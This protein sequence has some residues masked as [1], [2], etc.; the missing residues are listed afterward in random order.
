MIAQGMP[1]IE[2]NR[3]T[4]LE[5]FSCFVAILP[6]FN[7]DVLHKLYL[8]IFEKY[9]PQKENNRYKLRAITCADLLQSPE[10]ERIG[11]NSFII[12]PSL[13]DQLRHKLMEKDPG[14]DIL[15]D[16]GNFMLSYTWECKAHFPSL[17][18]LE[19][20]RIE[21]NIILNPI[22]EA[23]RVTQNIV[24]RFNRLKN[25][26]DR[27]N[28]VGYYLKVLNQNSL[29]AEQEKLVEFLNIYQSLDQNTEQVTEPQ[30]EILRNLLNQDPNSSESITIKLPNEIKKKIL[31][32]IKATTTTPS[33]LHALIIGVDKYQNNNSQ[34]PT[35]ATSEAQAVSDYL[36]Q[37]VAEGRSCNT[38]L[39][40]NQDANYHAIQDYVT[41]YLFK[42]IKPG[43]SFVLY[44]IGQGG[45]VNS[46]DLE[47]QVKNGNSSHFNLSPLIELA[48]MLQKK[49]IEC[50]ILNDESTLSLL[51]LLVYLDRL[52]RDCTFT[53]ILD[54]EFN[55]KV[56]PVQLSKSLGDG[57][58]KMTASDTISLNGVFIKNT[59]GRQ[60]AVTTTE[61]GYFTRSLLH[62]LQLTEKNITNQQLIN[63][64]NIFLNALKSG[65]K[66]KVKAFGN[67]SVTD[68][69]LN[70]FLATPFAECLKLIQTNKENKDPELKLNGM[71]LTFLPQALFDLEHLKV[72]DI[73][74]NAIRSFPEIMSNLINLEEINLNDNPIDPSKS[75]LENLK[76]L[77]ILKMHG[78][79]LNVFPRLI[80]GLHQLEELDLSNNTIRFLPN[81]LRN[82]PNLKNLHLTG[83]PLNFDIPG[84]G[85][86][87]MAYF[88]DLSGAENS[89]TNAPLMMVISLDYDNRLPNI[90]PE[91]EQ[92]SA[93]C[94]QSDLEIIQL[95]NP[96][97]A[98][99]NNS[100][101]MYQNRLAIIHFASFDMGVLADSD[102]KPQKMQPKDW[103][104]FFKCIKTE[105]F[106]TSLLFLNSCYGEDLIN[107]L[108]KDTFKLGLGLKD[109]I[110][111]WTAYNFATQFYR[112]LAS[113]GKTIEEAL[114]NAQ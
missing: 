102:R 54:T 20:Y 31:E 53:I 81:Q 56:D 41:K 48:L 9:E 30:I 6:W 65:Q 18:H 26:K 85:N 90:L 16:I 89:T 25:Q 72:L 34:I 86:N 113:D 98:E 67:A 12:N 40:L 95:T 51:D 28:A 11:Y 50:L 107:L 4:R 60:V 43:D 79:S 45:Y 71:G 5:N 42:E 22:A 38:H 66:T 10:V 58:S 3:Q 57:E 69:F 27:K 76:S 99:L 61:H 103:L 80:L 87:L 108:L 63:A 62:T 1:H 32:G 114:M 14:N 52:P 91:V 29:T 47:Q 35:F 83:N 59:R 23:E 2:K 46:K 74:D 49:Q 19:S 73:S 88:R 17:K 24:N 101:H 64:I 21:G 92:I 78:C 15:V 109:K 75:H 44:F 96:T 8:N 97:A 55:Q 100:I 82:L 13:Q 111:D 70:G 84:S 36:I 94:R 7:I 110:D 93:I 77:K 33:T 39:L 112:A 106:D 68:E 37:N 104:E 105:R